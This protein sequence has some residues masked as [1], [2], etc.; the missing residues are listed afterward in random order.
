MMKVHNKY[1]DVVYNNNNDDDNE[2]I[3]MIKHEVRSSNG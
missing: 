2:R 1:Y 3:M